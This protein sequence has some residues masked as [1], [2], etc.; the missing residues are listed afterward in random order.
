MS[1]VDKIG[2]AVEDEQNEPH[3]RSV[4]A[5][6]LDGVGNV[7][8]AISVSGALGGGAPSVRLVS[9]ED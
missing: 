7:A 3:V 6:V 5:P 1:K 8:G 2:C 9:D 4:A